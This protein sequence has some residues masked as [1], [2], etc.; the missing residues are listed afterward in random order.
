MWLNR[1][2]ARNMLELTRIRAGLTPINTVPALPLFGHQ[3]F[4]L[5]NTLN[6]LPEPT[7]NQRVHVMDCGNRQSVLENSFAI[8]VV[9]MAAEIEFLEINVFSLEMFRIACEKDVC[10]RVEFL[11]LQAPLPINRFNQV[12]P[13]EDTFPRKNIEV[14]ARLSFICLLVPELFTFSPTLFP[15]ETTLSEDFAILFLRHNF[16]SKLAPMSI[17]PIT[18]RGKPFQS[19]NKP[20]T[21]VFRPASFLSCRTKLVRA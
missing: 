1:L 19:I 8:S 14:L 12:V 5:K 11:F 2:V 3:V 9:V 20:P 21:T 13:E 17:H 6:L 15:S 10:L 16:P 18:Q 4:F 7:V